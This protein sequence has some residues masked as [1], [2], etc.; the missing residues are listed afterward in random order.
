[1]DAVAVAEQFGKEIR[2]RKKK[3]KKRSP[4]VVFFFSL[5][6]CYSDMSAREQD[7]GRRRRGGGRRQGGCFS[8]L[9]RASKLPGRACLVARHGFMEEAIARIALLLPKQPPLATQRRSCHSLRSLAHTRTHT[10]AMKAMS[11]AKEVVYKYIYLFTPPPPPSS[12][13][14]HLYVVAIVLLHRLRRRTSTWCLGAEWAEM[15]VNARVLVS[16]ASS[17]VSRLCLAA[18]RVL[19]PLS[20]AG[21][22]PWWWWCW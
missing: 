18:S 16:L 15:N 14:G 10:H 13:K 20:R 9:G 1:M 4:C 21:M 2:R 7:I 3:K 6:F 5:A 8:R 11:T 19:S 12:I 22:S 17:A